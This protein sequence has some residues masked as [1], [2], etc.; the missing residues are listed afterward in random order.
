MSGPCP[1]GHSSE[2]CRGWDDATS[3]SNN[4]NDQ[5]EPM[6]NQILERMYQITNKV[7]ECT[8]V[9][10]T[11]PSVEDTIKENYKIQTDGDYE[12]LVKLLHDQRV[13]EVEGGEEMK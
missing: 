10:I 13:R 7:E 12:K 1:S 3:G 6:I 5:M 8:G 9:Q 4:N 11:Q 2:V